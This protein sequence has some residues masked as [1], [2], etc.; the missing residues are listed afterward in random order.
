[1]G[2]VLILNNEKFDILNVSERK[3]SRKDVRVLENVFYKFNLDVKIVM[4]PTLKDIKKYLNE[5]L[6]EPLKT[7][8]CLVVVLM[9]HGLENDH[10]YAKDQVYNIGEVILNSKAF[11]EFKDLPKLFIVQACKN[12]EEDVQV[13]AECSSPIVYNTFRYNSCFEGGYSVR[14]D[15]GSIFIQRLCDNLDKY[16]LND[17]IEIIAAKVN[18]HFEMDYKRTGIKQNPT[19]VRYNKGFNAFCFGDHVKRNANGKK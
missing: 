15:R 4:D 1:M 11:Q 18:K 19:V 12:V 2:I 13:T 5:S 9:T 3:N 10:A 6:L 17:D 14:A 8:T 7:A 16:G